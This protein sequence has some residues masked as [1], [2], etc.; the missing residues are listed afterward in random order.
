MR[1]ERGMWKS[2]KG[3]KGKCLIKLQSQKYQN[4]S[5]DIRDYGSASVWTSR[6]TE[7]QSY[8]STQPLEL[9]KADKLCKPQEGRESTHSPWA[10]RGERE[11]E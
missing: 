6:K 4:K 7:P 11:K 9:D 5:A 8:N 10:I 3:G 2:L 1:V